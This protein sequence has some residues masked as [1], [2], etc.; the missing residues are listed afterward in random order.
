[1]HTASEGAKSEVWLLC[2]YMTGFWYFSQGHMSLDRL[3]EYL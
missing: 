3:R 2:Q 1:M